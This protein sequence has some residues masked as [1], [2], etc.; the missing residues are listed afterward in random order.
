MTR[1]RLLALACALGALACCGQPPS[2]I[3]PGPAP[4][5]D[6]L[7]QV[8]AA[9]HAALRSMNARARATSWIGGDRLR[10]TVLMLVARGGR[11]RIEAEVSLQ[12]T[13][14]VL[15]TNG[16]RFQLLDIRSNQLQQG[17]ACPANVASLIRIPLDPSEVAAILLGDAALPPAAATDDVSVTWDGARAADVLVIRRGATE[18]RVFFRPRGTDWDIVGAAVSAA[19]PLWRTSY[20]DLQD[21]PGNLRLPSLIRFAEGARSFDDG[22]EIRFKDRTP[23]AEL[24]EDSFVIQPPAGTKVVEVG[25]A[26]AAGG[27]R[28][29]IQGAA[30]PP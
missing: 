3:R 4:T 7:A 6:Q 23:N 14:S 8:L 16:G 1:A 24:T 21:A 29:D 25:C 28:D 12:G 17:P 13:V 20:E 27:P 2:A 11:M 5:A 18:A 10:A 26:G 15:T 19:S 22:V 9:R 30:A